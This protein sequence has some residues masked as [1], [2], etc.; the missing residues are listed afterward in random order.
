MEAAGGYGADDINRLLALLDRNSSLDATIESVADGIVLYDRAGR[1]VRMNAAAERLM[2]CIPVDGPLTLESQMAGLQPET[3]D[4]RPVRLE[5]TPVWRAL[6]GERAPGVAMGLRL[7]GRVLWVAAS[8]APVR[9]GDGTMLGVVATF[10][11]IT[12]L[13]E[14]KQQSE[15]VLRAVSHDLRSPLTAIQGYAQLLE[16]EIRR[17]ALGDRAF[18]SVD[19]IIANAKKM[20]SM[21]QDLVDRAS[22]ESGHL[23]L[24]R[25]DLELHSFMH[26]L[27]E[28][29]ATVL[30]MERVR[31]DVSEALPPVSADPDRLE[32]IL[33]NL[34]SNAL[35]YS[36]P[37][38]E[39][40]V[41]AQHTHDQVSVSVVD[42]GVGIAAEDMPHMFD[43]F[44]RARSSRK[45]DGLGLGLFITKTLV[46][47]HGGR[48]W[49]Q[50]EPG[51][52][53]VFTF[54][55]P[56]AITHEL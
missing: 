51:K 26:G 34:L 19:A 31:I 47:A 8:A 36:A 6:Q 27:K 25:V 40:L 50:S 9:A 48:I 21:I 39:V 1:I 43:R 41:K 44:Y 28:R 12:V 22:A 38:T 14:L 15:D 3:T 13:G 30:D 32:R 52:G 16:R 42:R 2:G 29:L 11:D 45:A 17:S 10:T 5:E 54:T 7:H 23:K 55:L 20:N 37:D 18:R 46:E 35:K 53:S 4:G 24:N 56:E 49:V 33:T